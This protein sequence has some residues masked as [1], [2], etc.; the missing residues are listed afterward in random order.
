M[1]RERHGM[2]KSAM[3]RLSCT[4][5]C[6]LLAAA[7]SCG[8]TGSGTAGQPTPA[9][10]ASNSVGSSN[11][12]D[13]TSTSLGSSAAPAGGSST[14]LG[15]GILGLSGGRIGG[16]RPYDDHPR[17]HGDG[18]FELP[19]NRSVHVHNHVHVD[20]HD[21]DREHRNGVRPAGSGRPGDIVVN[22]AKTYQAISGFGASSAWEGGFA[23]AADADTI[24][25]ATAGAGL[26]LLRVRI[27]PDGTTAAGGNRHG[28][29]GP[30][31]RCLGLG[32]AVVTAPGRQIE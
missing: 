23:N 17:F 31:A 24:L 19:T 30:A 29:G 3:Q 18:Q 32:Y 11:T 15:G 8:A 1:P 25:S 16:L 26:S 12:G 2:M 6:V 28:E 4:S 7:T 9:S 14:A 13:A 27:A 22:P 21:H 5:L 10:T 20:D